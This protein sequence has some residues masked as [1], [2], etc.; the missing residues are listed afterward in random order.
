[1]STERDNVLESRVFA[2]SSFFSADYL[3][4][5]I[6]ILI[7]LAVIFIFLALLAIAL[8]GIIIYRV[9]FL[10]RAQ[11]YGDVKDFFNARLKN[12]E[13]K[14]TEG[15]PRQSAG[16]AAPG[17]K[18]AGAATV[19]GNSSF[20]L[21]SEGLNDEDALTDLDRAVEQVMH[22]NL[23]CTAFEN[24]LA[25][26]TNNV[27]NMRALHSI[28]TTPLNA[29]LS[30]I[31]ENKELERDQARMAI[32]IRRRQQLASRDVLPYFTSSSM[33][34]ENV[35]TRRGS[36]RIIADKL[37]TIERSGIGFGPCP[38]SETR[39]RAHQDANNT[40]INYDVG[41]TDDSLLL[42]SFRDSARDRNAAS[43]FISHIF[44]KASIG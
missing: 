10:N 33:F 4:G 9:F 11:F 42:E 26:T 18:D 13:S 25:D 20:A 22:K 37:E 6:Q 31:S 39:T 29:N 5:S 36:T 12:K 17:E 3:L 24:I 21:T 14:Q 1:M 32:A 43:N 38:G 35:L 44:Q 30:G 23:W 41:S 34:R 8:L 7:P 27:R 2:E 28:L 16:D 40:S 19:Q 15:A